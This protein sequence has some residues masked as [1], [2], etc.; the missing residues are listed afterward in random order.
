M[1]LPALGVF[2]S[3][4]D[5]ASVG[6]AAAI[7]QLA[8]NIATGNHHVKTGTADTAW[9]L[10]SAIFG[11]LFTS[12]A[13]QTFTST[14]AGTYTP[15]AG[16]KYCLVISTGAGGGGG[17]ADT[18]GTNGSVAVGSGGGAGGT[19]ISI[20]SA[21]TIGASQSLSV[22]SG[23]AAGDNAGGNG[24][25]GGNTTF[26]AIH[27]ATG[28]G[29]GT[30][31]GTSGATVAAANAPSGGTPTGGT[32]NVKGGDGGSG[33]GGSCDGTTD[34]TFGLSGP[35]GGSF[36]GGGS[37]SR[38]QGSNVLNSDATIAGSSSAVP[39]AGGSGGVCLDTV[40]GVTGGAGGPGLIVIIE[41]LGPA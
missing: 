33:I 5:P 27:T 11:E 36:W 34:L 15:A 29:A 7:G 18:D 28:G 26:G 32:L 22:G 19:C 23:G 13:L 37:R 2:R 6:L 41:F 38:A 3:N 9:S 1:S 16:M 12:V 8:V 30:G 4:G 40:S 20:L 25:A 14:G 35:G 24:G 10:A 21:A 17:G 39:G 31:S